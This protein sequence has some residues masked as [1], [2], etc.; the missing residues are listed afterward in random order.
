MICDDCKCR[1]K[2]NKIIS[3]SATYCPDRSWHSA[4]TSKT[5]KMLT[6]VLQSHGV[7]NLAMLENISAMLENI[8][9]WR[10][11][12]NISRETNHDL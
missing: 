7:Y 11:A 12:C 1:D 10:E 4:D 2:C 9:A 6:K 8:S 3:E 5:V